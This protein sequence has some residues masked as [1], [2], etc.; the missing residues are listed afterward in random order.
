M[1]TSKDC[2]PTF[3]RWMTWGRRHAWKIM[4]L[5]LGGIAVLGA[6]V[7]GVVFYVLKNRMLP[8]ED[9]IVR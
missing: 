1:P 9:I 7:V 3:H 2:L 6:A 5:A 4:G 8:I